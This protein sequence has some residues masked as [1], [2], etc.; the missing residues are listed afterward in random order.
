MNASAPKISTG[1]TRTD[2]VTL[3]P[4]GSKCIKDWLDAVPESAEKLA[5]PEEMP[6]IRLRPF[7]QDCLAGGST[8]EVRWSSLLPTSELE[9]KVFVECQLGN[10]AEWTLVG[11]ACLG[12][13]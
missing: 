5:A 2:A 7:D 10:D 9:K 13:G 1:I 12:E 3:M 6:L 11:E 8:Q 4:V